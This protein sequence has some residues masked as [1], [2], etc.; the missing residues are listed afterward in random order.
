MFRGDGS[1]YEFKGDNAG[2]IIQ[3][4]P[5]SST[6]LSLNNEGLT[7]GMYEEG[8]KAIDGLSSLKTNNYLVYVMGAIHAKKHRFNDCLI[9]NTNSRICDSTIANVFWVKEKKIYTPPLSEGCVAG[10]MRANLL[11]RIPNDGLEVIEKETTEQDLL[12]ADEVFLTNALN[13][14]R[15]VGQFKQ[16]TYSNAIASRLYHSTI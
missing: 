14:I 5:L 3:V 15:W 16:K 10:V 12:D 13:G 9:L 4:W 7:L 1:L 2:F 11:A 8:R 6:N